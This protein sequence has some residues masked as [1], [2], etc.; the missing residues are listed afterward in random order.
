M[1]IND[2]VILTIDKVYANHP[3]TIQRLKNEIERQIRKIH[4]PLL[5]N[6]LRNFVKTIHT[7]HQTNGGH[8]TDILF[9]I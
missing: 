6:V 4:R 2:K 9:H 3:E 7:C 5:Q 1:K 8:L